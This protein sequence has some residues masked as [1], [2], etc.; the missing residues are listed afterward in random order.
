MPKEIHELP[1]DTSILTTDVLAKDN[2]A[3][4]KKVTLA[5]I[6]KAAIEEYAATQLGGAEQSLQSFA[7]NIAADVAGKSGAMLSTASGRPLAL[8]EAN[9]GSRL[10]ALLV[11][12]SPRTG[13]TSAVTLTLS[14]RAVVADASVLRSSGWTEELDHFKAT[15]T[16]IVIN[17]P[18]AAGATTLAFRVKGKG[19]WEIQQSAGLSEQVTSFQINTDAVT[20][21]T[22]SITNASSYTKITIVPPAGVACEI[23][24]FV[25]YGAL[26]KSE[27]KAYDWS[28]TAGAVQTGTLDVLNGLLT[29][30]SDTYNVDALEVKAAPEGYVLI[31]DTSTAYAVPEATYP[32]STKVYI[33]K[34]VADSITEPY[35]TDAN[36]DGNV[37]LFLG[38]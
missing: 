36:S 9:P 33:D 12:I 14:Q 15:G 2:G 10:A 25:I 28:A 17:G 20:Y 38:G 13:G 37:V 35:A 24:S 6:A 8:T 4:T 19:T 34:L 21:R 31:I 27:T 32:G 30:G 18:F 1:A 26:L 3:T 16:S 22:Q 5:A 11:N 29:V 7:D 23:Y